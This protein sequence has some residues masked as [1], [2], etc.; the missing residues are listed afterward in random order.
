MALISVTNASFG[1]GSKKVFDRISFSVAKG[2]IF[3]LIGPNGCGKTT[4]LDCLLGFHVLRS[5]TLFID[6]KD[7][8]HFRKG[9]LARSIAYVPQNHERAFPY[10]VKEIVVMGRSAHLN[11][12]ASPSKMDSQ[13]AEHALDC[14][15]VGHLS[16]RPY[17]QLS[18]GELQLV[19]IARAITQQA[20]VIVMDEPTAHLDFRYELMV[21]EVMCELVK[22][23]KLSIIMATH[24]PNH[25]FY[26]Q[27][28]G[29]ETTVALLHDTRFLAVGT[30]EAI[31]DETRL[32]QLYGVNA[33]L[34]DLKIDRDTTLKHIIPIST[35]K[36][37]L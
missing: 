27:N 17:T 14:I 22:K 31:L 26:F 11:F 23:N 21:L 20:P 37:R 3:C 35:R 18:G 5:G 24:F 7:A 19:M 16:E 13:I 6:G 8:R 28:N 33:R 25:A 34:I 1:Y 2:E 12:L 4:L 9:H 15:G 32:R 30:P 29:I 36:E 10:T